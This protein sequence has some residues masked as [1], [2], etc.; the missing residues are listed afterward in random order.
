[1]KTF[2]KWAGNKTS[3][4]PKISPHFKGTKLIEPFAGSCAVSLNTD[5]ESYHCNDINQDLITMYQMI[6]TDC[7]SFIEDIRKYFQNG[8]S[9]ERFAELRELYNSTDDKETKAKL[10][11]Y[12]N[13]H[14]FN[15]LC[16]YNKKGKFNVPFGTYSSPYF[17]E[18]EIL[19]FASYTKDR[20]KFTNSKF[21]DVFSEV[22]S[23]TTIYSDPPYSALTDTANFANYTGNDFNHSAHIKLRDLSIDAVN[24]F[25][26]IAIIS[27]HDTDVTRELYK[28]AEIVSFE[29]KRT[30]S[31]K[32]STRKPAGELIAIYRG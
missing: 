30:I 7:N 6:Q 20:F 29:V 17:P 13:R 8:N 19:E 23:K 22:D 16:R 26:C 21:E 14:C 11:V 3:V 18:K 9:S 31:S 12:L 10:F 27:N 32:S 28:D 24:K 4:V 25:G 5:F 15:G 1:M 2:L